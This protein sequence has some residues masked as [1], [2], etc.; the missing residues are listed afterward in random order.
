MREKECVYMYVREEDDRE[1]GTYMYVRE[2][3]LLCERS[4]ERRK[5]VKMYPCFDVLPLG[6]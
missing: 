2:Y 6:Y 1:M 3:V 5:R 4:I